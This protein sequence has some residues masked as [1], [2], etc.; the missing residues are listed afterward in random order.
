MMSLYVSI[1]YALCTFQIRL[2]IYVSLLLLTPK[3]QCLLFDPQDKAF[4]SWDHSY[5]AL[6]KWSN[7]WVSVENS[8][9]QWKASVVGIAI[10]RKRFSPSLQI[11]LQRQSYVM[12]LLNLMTFNNPKMDWCNTLYLNY[13]HY[14]TFNFADCSVF[15]VCSLHL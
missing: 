3:I 8:L 1:L 12:L 7:Y 10:Q 13:G 6:H 2:I 11:F 15:A 4:L 5:A 9:H 14:E